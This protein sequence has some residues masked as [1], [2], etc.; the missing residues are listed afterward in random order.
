MAPEQARGQVS[1]IGP[2]TDIWAMG[3]IALQLLTGEIYWQ[4]NPVA[5]L[6]VR[7]LSDTF[8]MPSERWDLAPTGDRHMVLALVRAR[9]PATASQ[10]WDSGFTSSASP[11]ARSPTQP[12]ASPSRPARPSPH[13]RVAGPRST[14]R[15]HLRLSARQTT[16]S[17]HCG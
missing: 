1:E 8:Y 6:M 11:S 2:S 4:A 7:I 10:A 9:A 5:E 12:R 3:L 17:A 15:L 14:R 16:T 13:P